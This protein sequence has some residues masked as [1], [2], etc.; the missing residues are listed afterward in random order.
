MFLVRRRRN[1]LRF[2]QRRIRSDRFGWSWRHGWDD[3]HDLSTL[4]R[5]A[6]L[7]RSLHRLQRFQVESDGLDWDGVGVSGYAEEASACV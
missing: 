7:H 1:I 5:F 3:H 2:F 6:R 4:R